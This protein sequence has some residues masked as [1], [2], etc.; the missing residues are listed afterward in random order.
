MYFLVEKKLD[1]QTTKVVFYC[2]EIKNSQSFRWGFSSFEF[3]TNPRNFVATEYE[4]ILL[5]VD[6]IPR[7]PLTFLVLASPMPGLVFE[8]QPPEIRNNATMRVN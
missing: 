7:L 6:G 4:L 1:Q 5:D 8:T 2:V 3:L